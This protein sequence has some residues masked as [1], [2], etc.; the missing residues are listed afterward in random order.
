MA[1]KPRLRLEVEPWNVEALL[2]AEQ[3]DLPRYFLLITPVEAQALTEGIVGTRVREAA[4]RLSHEILTV[5]ADPPGL[6]QV[7]R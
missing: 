7:P 2:T 6:P 4:A 5:P 3:F 1:K